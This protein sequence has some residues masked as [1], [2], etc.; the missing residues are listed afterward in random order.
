MQTGAG[1]RSAGR[2]R[3]PAYGRAADLAHGVSC[4]EPPNK[5]RPHREKAQ[6]PQFATVIRRTVRSLTPGFAKSKSGPPPSEQDLANQSG[7]NLHTRHDLLTPIDGGCLLSTRPV[8][9]VVYR[10][11]KHHAWKNRNGSD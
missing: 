11:D 10:K 8:G 4:N 1:T 2:S 7:K 9:G 6:A 3:P 5:V